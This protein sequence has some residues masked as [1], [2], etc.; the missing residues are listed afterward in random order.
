MKCPS[1]GFLE[2]KVT[3]SRLS[4][5]AEAVRRRRECESCSFRFTTYEER[6][7]IRFLVKKKSGL[8]EPYQREKLENGIRKALEKRPVNEEKIKQLVIAIEQELTS[9]GA[10]TI[11]SAEIGKTALKHLARLDKV[12][13]VRFASVYKEFKTM[14]GFLKEIQRLNKH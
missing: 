1:C 3:N 7:R 4:A 5:D 13:Y 11:E 14:T 10:Q 6:E 2:T 12:A 9:D 8:A